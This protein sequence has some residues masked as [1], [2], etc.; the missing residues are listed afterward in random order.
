[1]SLL[2]LAAMAVVGAMAPTSSMAA[3]NPD[4]PVAV[5][6]STTSSIAPVKLPG[7]KVARTY[8]S[9]EIK[10]H[11]RTG[12]DPAVLN[13]WTPKRMKQA[14]PLDAPGDKKIID[15]AVRAA[16]KQLPTKAT[17]PVAPSKLSNSAQKAPP[18]VTNF[19]VTNG[20]LFIG[21]LGSNSWC[22]ASAINSPSK[23]LVV[24]AGHCV[25]SGKGGT[26]RA[27][28]VFAP[29]YN[30][31]LANPYPRGAFQAY[32]LRTFN[33]W[34]SNSDLNRDV[35]FITTY[36]N[37][38]GQRVVDA[39]GGHG[40]VYNGGTEFDVT[41]FGYPS[42]RDNGRRMSACWGVA[43]DSSWFDNKSKIACNFGP[44]SSGGPWLWS[45][46]NATGQGYVRSVMSTIDGAGVNRGPYFDTAVRDMKN[47]A[48]N[49]WPN[50]A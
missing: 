34:A 35:A 42:N 40:F 47:N 26:W 15:R 20:K 28:L 38:A 29:G 50:P 5:D 12:G 16:I 10:A 49:D 30:A 31:Y 32:R 19:S 23:R 43:K 6:T 22:S 41:I 46:S 13:Y 9:A 14:K 3:P 44:G 45:Y 39:V 27:N 11:D 48:N 36:Q 1:M 8:S 7:Q 17:K 25:H 37:A 4:V 24:T 33:A 21:G 2:S 18:P